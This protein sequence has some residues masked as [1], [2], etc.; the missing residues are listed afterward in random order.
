MTNKP[1]SFSEVLAAVIKLQEQYSA[2]N[3]APMEERGLLIRN[4]GPQQ[5]RNFF[6][7]APDDLPEGLLAQGGDGSGRKTRVPWI[8]MFLETESPSAT[9]GW[10]LVYLFAADGGAVY[11]SLNQGTNTYE[12]GAPHRRPVAE[13]MARSEWAR[14]LLKREI[15]R[16]D[17]QLTRI[18]LK[19][20]PGGVGEGYEIGNVAAI[21]YDR[22][23]LPDDETLFGDMIKMVSLLMTLYSQPNEDPWD[24]FISWA[25][26]FWEWEEFDE[27]ER[28]QARDWSQAA[29]SSR[30]VFERRR[31]VVPHPGGCIRPTEQP[32]SMASAFSFRGTY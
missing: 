18:A 23:S 1:E 27:Q 25:K 31:A 12:R 4:D 8:R 2:E 29:R 5:L 3:T 9:I 28:L 17:R 13:I 11:L 7:D 14:D 10:Y 26:K 16:N 20:V 22:E 24:E 21:R 30:R 6:F 32:D 15:A 19:D